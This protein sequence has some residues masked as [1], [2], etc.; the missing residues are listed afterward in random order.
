M[1]YVTPADVGVSDNWQD[2]IN[3]NSAEPGTD[4]MTE[5]GTDLRMPG[6]GVI[7]RVD[8]NPGGAEGRRLQLY[9]DN[10]QV[11]DFI[12]GYWIHGSE[13]QR[14]SQGQ[15]GIFISGASGWG[16]DYYYG[17]HVHVTLRADT[18]KPFKDTLDFEKYIDITIPTIPQQE[19]TEMYPIQHHDGRIFTIGKQYIK[20]EI[21]VGAAQYTRNVIT[22]DDKFISVNHDEFIAL[23]DSFGIPRD[24]VPTDGAVWSRETQIL[25]TTASTASEAFTAP[26]WV[27][28]VALGLIAVATFVSIFL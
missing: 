24:V 11:I 7:A 1:G 28:A 10:G 26:V 23:L 19:V 18:G 5:Y 14:V 13:G 27:A 21:S 2:H 16:E 17:A 25:G 9:M 8:N 22:Q 15:T 20:H 12:H 4:Y 3:R 6:D